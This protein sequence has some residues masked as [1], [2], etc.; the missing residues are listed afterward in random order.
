MNKLSIFCKCQSNSC[1]RDWRE[2]VALCTWHVTGE[3]IVKGLGNDTEAICG[4]LLAVMV[5][6]WLLQYLGAGETIKHVIHIN[7]PA[8][9]VSLDGHQIN[10]LPCCPSIKLKITEWVRSSPP[11]EF[12]N[13]SI[14]QKTTHS[15]RPCIKIAW[16]KTHPNLDFLIETTRAW[17]SLSG[18]F[19]CTV[20]PTRKQTRI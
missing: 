16:L 4:G 14:I 11:V 17:S 19:I 12:E 1:L 13:C 5:K 6:V 2:P 18:L 20:W 3:M 15:V 7:L 8:H 10:W 9:N